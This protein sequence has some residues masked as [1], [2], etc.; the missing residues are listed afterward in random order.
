M[1]ARFISLLL[2]VLLGLIGC[3]TPSN[4][5]VIVAETPMQQM[6]RIHNECERLIPVLSPYTTALSRDTWYLS[7]EGV[8]DAPRFFSEQYFRYLSADEAKR[9]GYGIIQ[10]FFYKGTHGDEV[11]V[12]TAGGYVL[13]AQ[14]RS[15]LNYGNP[16]G[17]WKVRL[18]SRASIDQ[19]TPIDVLVESHWFYRQL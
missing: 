5:N 9:L 3:A 1:I 18:K 13:F 15:R 16:C 19:S 14:A 17:I 12:S 2:V 4:R 6:A 10:Y 7:E 8:H 11:W